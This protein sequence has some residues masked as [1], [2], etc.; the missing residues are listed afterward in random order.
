[1]NAHTCYLEWQ[2]AIH[3]WWTLEIHRVANKTKPIRNPPTC[4]R[5]PRIHPDATA[6][7]TGIQNQDS[8]N[9][10][11]HHKTSCQCLSCRERISADSPNPSVR[12]IIIGKEDISRLPWV[13]YHGWERFFDK[14]KSIVR[15]VPK[16]RK[17]LQI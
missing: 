12:K 16:K 5:R 6:T 17:L 14:A 3:S 15:F 1:L 10:K 11:V 9:K 4:C 2:A 8:K 13:D 7:T